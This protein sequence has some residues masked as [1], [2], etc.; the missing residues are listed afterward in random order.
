MIAR[1]ALRAWIHP[2]REFAIRS[3]TLDEATALRGKFWDCKRDGGVVGWSRKT[4]ANPRVRKGS[5]AAGASVALWMAGRWKVHAALAVGIAAAVVERGD[6]GRGV[7][8][9]P[10]VI[11]M[12][13]EIEPWRMALM[14]WSREAT[15]HA[16]KFFRP[17]I[18]KLDKYLSTR[19]NLRLGLAMSAGAGLWLLGGS[20]VNRAAAAVF[21]TASGGRQQ[22][23]GLIG[24]G[25]Y[26]IPGTRHILLA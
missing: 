25:A 4:W 22:R 24:V 20:V 1:T 2:Y 11:R 12:Q 19:P 6:K 5:V 13:M 10:W 9:R 26:C 15:M 17:Y 18:R 21:L 8:L 23:I 14:D 7:R 16:E 3:I